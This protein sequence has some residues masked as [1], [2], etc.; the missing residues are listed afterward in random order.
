M[1]HLNGRLSGGLHI[2]DVEEVV[3]ERGEEGGDGVVGSLEVNSRCQRKGPLLLRSLQSK[4][5]EN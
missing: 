4:I 3:G 2:C 5:F 1:K